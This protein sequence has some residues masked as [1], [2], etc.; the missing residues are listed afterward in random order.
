MHILVSRSV[1]LAL[2]AALSL[3]LVAPAAAD[4]EA[5]RLSSE[6]V[7]TVAARAPK[8]PR[9][10]YVG[11]TFDLGMPDI[12]SLALVV[13]PLWWL[14]L[15]A[16]GS[17]DFF[18]GGLGGGVV[19]VPLRYRF[20][21]GIS[22][23]G[24]HMFTA[25]TLGVPR[26]F[27]VKVDGQR[28]GYDFASLHAGLEVAVHRRVSLSARFGVSFIDLTA[29]PDGTRPS[30]FVSADLKIWTPSGKLALTVFL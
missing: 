11:L 22:I 25:P 10:S 24:G 29:V 20:S 28:V 1:Q 21:P 30:S 12:M 23:E 16:G 7:A 15:Q 9:P 27:G 19:F 17:T 8:P 4:P 26:A 5:P 2:F 13:R 14:R 6:A 3:A 18:S